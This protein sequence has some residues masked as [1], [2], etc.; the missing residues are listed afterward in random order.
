MTAIA[1]ELRNRTTTIMT[2]RVDGRNLRPSNPVGFSCGCYL[3]VFLAVFVLLPTLVPDSVSAQTNS[4]NLAEM[5]R[6]TARTVSPAVIAIGHVDNVA[7]SRASTTDAQQ[8]IAI[9]TLGVAISGDTLICPAH[10]LPLGNNCE[11]VLPKT[12]QPITKDGKSISNHSRLQLIAIE[13]DYDIAVFKINGGKH[14]FIPIAPAEKLAPADL[15]V[16]FG[17]RSNKFSRAKLDIRLGLVSDNERY[18]LHK[19]LL[20]PW[21]VTDAAIDLGSRGTIIVNLKG[22]L[23]GLGGHTLPQ[24]ALVGKMG[25]ARCCEAVFHDVLSR[26]RKGTPVQP[27]ALGLNVRKTDEGLQVTKVTP[28][29]PAKTAG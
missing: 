17:N 23:V 2:N 8:Q 9:W 11:Y 18:L 13:Y 3:T 20:T 14:P 5:L 4:A 25:Y 24:Q 16:G 26:L 1:D 10:L 29:G 21:L 12:N 27:G 22:Q 19:G 6:H 15:V 7:S 28:A